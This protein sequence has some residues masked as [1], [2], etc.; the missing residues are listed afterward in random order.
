LRALEA[1]DSTL[2]PYFDGAD[3][4]SQPASGLRAA[5][6]RLVNEASTIDD[7]LR[8]AFTTSGVGTG[9]A[10]AALDL[11]QHIYRAQLD[12]RFIDSFIHH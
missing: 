3:G 9:A 1:L 10:N 11:R 4:A 12:A 6:A 8:G 7:V 5:S 2:A